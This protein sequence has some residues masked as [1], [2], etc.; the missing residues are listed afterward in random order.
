MALR[1]L[2]IATA[3]LVA[4]TTSLAQAPVA[5]TPSAPAAV[6]RT[7]QTE[8]IAFHTDSGER[9]TVPVRLSG[10]G[11]YRFLIDTGADRTA[12]SAELASRLKY[13]PGE[14]AAVH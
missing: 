14:T 2:G 9:M 11:P 7:T 8:D 5:P 10:T 6:Y 4:S 3:V 12:I 1:L 13:A